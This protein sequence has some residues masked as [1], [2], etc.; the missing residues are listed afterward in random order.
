[1]NSRFSSAVLPLAIMLSPSAYTQDNSMF[2]LDTMVVTAA[3]HAQ[4]VD[5]TLAAVSLITRDEIERSQAT[6]V[7]ELIDRT[8]GVTITQNGGAG[9]VS[10]V[11]IRGT[12][13]S[14]A[15]ILIDG[16]RINSANGGSAALQYLD[17]HQIERIEIVRGPRSSLYG[18]D[19]IGGVI[20]IFTR[21]GRGT[22]A[23]MLTAGAGSHGTSMVGVNFGGEVERTRFNISANT[24]TTNGY[25]FTNKD[26]SVD[27][28]LNNDSDSYR[29]KSVAI[30]VAHGLASG[31]EAG[32]TVSHNEGRASY[33]GTTMDAL[34]NSYPYDAY[35]LF[36]RTTASSWVNVPMNSLWQ[37]RLELGYSRDFNRELGKDI[38][39]ASQ[40]SPASYGTERLSLNWQNNIDWHESQQLTVGVDY[41]QDKADNSGGYENPQTGQKEDRRDNRAVFIQNQSYWGDS[42]VLIGLRQ[43]DNESYG[44]NTTGNIA[45]GYNLPRNMR[46]IAS[47][48]T[49][50]RA[51]TFNDLYYPVRGNPELKAESAKNAELELRGQYSGGRWAVA[52][53]QNDID[54]LI[55][56][57]PSDANDPN[58]Q[59]LPS[60]VDSARIRGMEVSVGTTF[61]DWQ[62]NTALTL[63]DPRDKTT[64]NYLVNRPRQRLVIDADKSLNDL[65]VGGT[66]RA[67]G[68]SYSNADNTQ[69]QSGFA[70]VDLR[71]SYKLKAEW[72]AGIKVTNVLNKS[73]ATARGYRAEPRGM[74]ATVT[75]RPKL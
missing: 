68:A 55:A 37:T 62:L 30:S 70:T 51:P 52:V 7:L 69:Q 48:G 74:L 71:A 50:F 33:D 41:Y 19:A 45:W 8:P 46:V 54:D 9:A 32:F 29:N 23:L 16:V 22:P 27:G 21:T 44:R 11:M 18:A 31:A 3:R 43:D 61:Y 64:G 15:L 2:M 20:Q 53:F 24:Q 40:F 39:P 38:D 25:D 60:N 63:L 42:D 34:W 14:Q 13:S 1:M 56:W 10:S 6:N 57:A 47:Y 4:S 59:W 66:L 17:P 28:G 58:S 49:A 12:S 67:Q 36:R 35:S 65:S 75:W 73:Y 26:S 72:Q 5:E